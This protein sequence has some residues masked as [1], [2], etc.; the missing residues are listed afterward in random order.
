[1]KILDTDDL[2]SGIS[3]V[4]ENLV[5]MANQIKE[6]RQ[7]VNNF[8]S[9]DE[10]FKGKGGQSI[11]M[12]Y[13]ETHVPFLLFFEQVLTSYNQILNKIAKQFKTFESSGDGYI[14]ESFIENELEEGLKKTSEITKELVD[15]ANSLIKSISDIIQLTGINDDQFHLNINDAQFYGR[16]TTER[17]NELDYRTTNSLTSTGEDLQLLLNYINEIKSLFQSGK[18][19]ISTYSFRQL[20]ENE[21]YN[22]LINGIKQQSKLTWK[23]IFAKYAYIP[24]NYVFPAIPGPI[25]I[26]YALMTNRYQKSISSK[27]EAKQ[28]VN[29]LENNRIIS[30]EEFKS[31]EKRLVKVVNIIDEYGEFGGDYHVYDNGLI[32]RSYVDKDEKSGEFKRIYEIVDEVPEGHRSGGVEELDSMFAGTPLEIV[33]YASPH[34]AIRKLGLKLFRK[35]L[36][37]VDGRDVKKFKDKKETDDVEG[38]KEKENDISK[39]DKDTGEI[40]KKA[41]GSNFDDIAKNGEKMPKHSEVKNKNS[42]PGKG[43]PNSSTDLLNPDGTV[44][45]RRYYDEQGRA[46]EDIDFNHSD[47]GTHTFPHRHKWDWSKKPPRQ[48]PE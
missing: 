18:I 28:I 42:L 46:K 48:K 19:T 29:E 22:S 8:S 34:N 23:E 6:I 41:S 47:D 31:L 36:K 32:V 10:E 44:K 3:K 45:Q 21:V 15:E 39:V 40:S 7:A 27:M 26:L 38:S 17:L 37:L 9:L 24:L 20:E 35:T 12:Y 4:T 13:N 11:R 1:M 5:L 16:K 33:E 30:P 25:D 43:E 2:N 14:S